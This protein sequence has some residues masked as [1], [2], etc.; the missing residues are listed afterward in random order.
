MHSDNIF[1]FRV[2]VI[3]NYVIYSQ[4]KNYSQIYIWRITEQILF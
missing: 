4:T 3:P 1:E 2:N